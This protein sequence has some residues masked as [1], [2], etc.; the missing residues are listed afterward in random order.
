MLCPIS[1][2][3]GR[4][5]LKPLSHRHTHFMGIQQHTSPQSA[6]GVLGDT[7]QAG[8]STQDGSSWPTSPCIFLKVSNWEPVMSMRSWPCPPMVGQSLRGR[9]SW[10]SSSSA[11]R[12]GLMVMLSHLRPGLVSLSHPGFRVHPRPCFTESTL[13][14]DT[15]V[16]AS[17]GLEC[18]G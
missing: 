14:L 9:G 1:R 7:I 18:G 11:S 8:A 13:D 6:I 5:G 2:M 15:E 10:L 17:G 3:G 12:L 4:R 16:A